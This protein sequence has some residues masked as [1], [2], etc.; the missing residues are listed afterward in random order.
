MGFSPGRLARLA[1]TKSRR[2][3][4]DAPPPSSAGAAAI[5]AAYDRD[6][7]YIFRRALSPRA[8][9]NLHAYMERE[10]YPDPTPLLRHPTVTLEPHA[11][12]T[13]A[14][15]TEFVANG[16]YNPH[17][18][19][20]SAALGDMLLRLVC[21][22]EVADLLE[23]V[24][25]DRQH[26]LHQLIM[27]FTPPHTE[28]HADGWSI[29]TMRPGDLCTLWI[30]LQ[31]ITLYNSPI[32]IF[33][34]PRGELLSPA[35]LGVENLS[36]YPPGEVYGVYHD[37]LCAFFDKRDVS[38]VVPLLKP[39][40]VVVFAST[41]P[42]ATMPSSQRNVIRRALQVLVRP[43]SARWGGILMSRLDGGF[44]DARDPSDT[45][46]NDRW[47]LSMSQRRKEQ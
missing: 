46:V 26:T 11:H 12:R 18:E 30:P 29:D 23:I 35:M 16:L 37:A 31:P 13:A 9:D 1:I 39:G 36:A 44:S 4:T 42:H 33:P 8:I 17:L 7:Y 22:D 32:C 2:K 27:F 21:N 47:I 20:R 25:G 45:A 40:D 5:R 15:G 34:W 28:T 43:S 6:G 24:D 19:T 10:I 41:T 38:V 3:P 14:D